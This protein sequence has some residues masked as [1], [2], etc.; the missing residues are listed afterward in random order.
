M[1]LID[2]A[3]ALQRAVEMHVRPR[4]RILR[5]SRVIVRANET[6]GRGARSVRC[7]AGCRICLSIDEAV[8][9]KRSVGDVETFNERGFVIL[10]RYFEWRVG[11]AARFEITY[12]ELVFFRKFDDWDLDRR[13]NCRVYQMIFGADCREPLLAVTPRVSFS[14]FVHCSDLVDHT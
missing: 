14:R 11:L 9:E 13:S 5:Q 12:D 7:H 4:A 10:D 1:H 2:V 6:L 8:T 3:A